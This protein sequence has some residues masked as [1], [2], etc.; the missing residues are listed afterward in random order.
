MKDVNNWAAWQ[1]HSLI[2]WDFFF[3]DD[4]T[5][6][7]NVELNAAHFISEPC[8]LFMGDPDKEVY[9]MPKHSKCQNMKAGRITSWLRSQIAGVGK[10][11]FYIGITGVGSS[12]IRLLPLYWDSYWAR[13]R[14]TWWQG[15][16]TEEAPATLVL[17]EHW[18][19]DAWEL[20]DLTYHAPMLP[21]M[22]RVGIGS[23]NQSIGYMR[24]WDNT[25]IEEWINEPCY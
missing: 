14:F 20:I 10:P 8:S 16:D 18:V 1:Q 15:L 21:G 11:Y 22:N 19:D 4:W 13:S 9:V 7:P 12:G 2:D 25:I 24:H 5:T 6:F 17:K 23:T 3:V